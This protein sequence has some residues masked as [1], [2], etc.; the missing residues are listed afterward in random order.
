MARLEAQAFALHYPRENAL[1]TDYQQALRSREALSADIHTSAV[2]HAAD[3]GEVATKISGLL[4]WAAMAIIS[5]NHSYVA[6]ALQV[7]PH[8]GHYILFGKTLQTQRI[9]GVECPMELELARADSE[10]ALTDQRNLLIERL[11][12]V[13]EWEILAR[14]RAAD[15]VIRATAPLAATALGRVHSLVKINQVREC[16]MCRNL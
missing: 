11:R 6:Q 1:V 12:A 2:Q 13:E 16:P 3:F 10:D 4:D 5:G 15:D 8:E 9:L 14:I 7:T